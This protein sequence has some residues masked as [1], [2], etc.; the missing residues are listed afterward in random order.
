[1]SLQIDY[2]TLR[3]EIGIFR[4]YRTAPSLW[5]ADKVA[6]V[7]K[8]LR[9]A[10]WRFYWPIIT[11]QKK[12]EKQ[13]P[14]IV[15]YVWS[16]LKPSETLTTISGENRYDLPDDFTDFSS[17]G[18]NYAPGTEKQMVSK[19]DSETMKSLQAQTD[20]SGP[21]KYFTV[22]AKKTLDGQKTMYEVIFYPNPDDAYVLSYQY[23][24]TPGEITAENP[25]HLGGAQHSQT[26]LQAC[27]AEAEA[28]FNDDSNG[29]EEKKFRELLQVSILLDQELTTPDSGDVWPLENPSTSLEVTK[30]YLKRLIGIELEYGPNPSLWDNTQAQMVKLG[31]E[32]GLRKFYSPVCLPGESY[33]HSWNFLT[34][35][36]KFYLTEGVSKYPLPE[37][38]V[39]MESDQMLYEPGASVIY[40]SIKL[41][42]ERQVQ[43]RLQRDDSAGRPEIV[44]YRPINTDAGTRYEAI[45]WPAPDDD[46]VL[47]YRP[48]INPGM[49][50][51]DVSLPLGGQANMQTVIEACL[52]AAEEIMDKP[53]IHGQLFTEYLRASVNRDRRASSPDT[54]GYNRDPSDTPE[55]LG[56]WGFHNCGNN[57]TS[58]NGVEY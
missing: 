6:D 38:F 39:M 28:L 49:L 10:C 45:F 43:S 40:P 54:L 19:V 27:F 42:S 29:E 4:G 36:K 3:S 25:Y 8:V 50:S 33:S 53:G 1:M 14:E 32:T 22:R 15:R 2:D 55:D 17:P 31:L 56:Y 30:S 5:S 57:I 23:S 24:I 46:Y 37:G 26:F 7:R 51:D 21:P 41:V 52:S 44:A 18:F 9:R 47:N 48:E 12:Y 11:K 34:E 58:Y 13:E 16:F 20:L 35:I